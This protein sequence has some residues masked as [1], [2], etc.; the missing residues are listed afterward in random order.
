M[1]II[2]LTVSS[3]IHLIRSD[4]NDNNLKPLGIGSGVIIKYKEKFFICT[5][6]HFS[7]HPNQN[8]GIV[9]GRVKDGS[10]EIYYLGDFSK[11]FKIQFEDMPDSEDLEYSFTHPEKSGTKLDM[12][13]REIP[14]LEN[15]Y[16]PE[17]IFNLEGIGEVKVNQGAKSI[18]V[19]DDEYEIVS[20]E[21]CSFY[22]RIMPDISRGIF[23]FKERLYYG[24]TIKGVKGNYVEF[25]LGSPIGDPKRFKGCSGAPIFDTRGRLIA[26]LSHGNED[27]TK[28]NIFGFRFDKVKQFIDL[29]YFQN[30]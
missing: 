14:L 25:D 28:S 15:I 24:L 30:I 10:S 18:I 12:A 2:E 13:V 29:M 9:T 21:L 23:E 7:E 22:G 20:E 16:Q 26:L 27:V 17:R 1:G 19:V 6:A 4:L 11:V 8:V 5:V 3:C